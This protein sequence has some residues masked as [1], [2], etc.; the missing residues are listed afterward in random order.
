MAREVADVKYMKSDIAT[1]ALHVFFF[2]KPH[3]IYGE[4]LD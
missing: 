1:V 4:R 3:R 2:T